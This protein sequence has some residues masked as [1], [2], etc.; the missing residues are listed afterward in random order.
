V[1]GEVPVTTV[2]ICADRR[3]VR[4]GLTRVLSAV[5]G[6]RRIDGAADG[7]ELLA[8]YAHH[9]ADLVLVGIQRG[10]SCGVDATRRLVVAHPRATVLVFGAADN[11][12]GV[13][14]AIAAGAHG[15]LRWDPT[16]PGFGVAATSTAAAPSAAMAA[17]GRGDSGPP[18]S[19]RELQVLVG[20]SQGKTNSQIGREL[21]LAR[22]TVK[23][24]AQ[25]LFRKFGVQDRAEAVAHGFRRGLVT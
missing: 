18:L 6:I 20:M 11:S 10:M 12:G 3:S 17:Q 8:R 15:Y 16:H 24:H 21:F 7:D 1:D 2:L 13:A 4:E 5:A 22:S 9:P 25:R 14:T 19:E 23:T